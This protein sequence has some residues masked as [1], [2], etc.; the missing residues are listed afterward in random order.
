MR[1]KGHED[2]ELLLDQGVTNL[3]EY[4]I[5]NAIVKAGDGV[6]LND[7]FFTLFRYKFLWNADRV[8]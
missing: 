6:P 4:C 1:E 2:V 8:G 7:Q 3:L 5:E